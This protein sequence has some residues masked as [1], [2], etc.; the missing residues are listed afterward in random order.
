M[1]TPI[2]SLVVSLAAETAAFRRDISAARGS[3]LSLERSVT[4]M[5]RS[6]K[7]A[8]A[9][10][11]TVRTMAKGVSSLAQS[12]MEAEQATAAL[13]GTVAGPDSLSA[14]V[15][16]ATAEWKDYREALATSPAFLGPVTAAVKALG[17]ALK[18][19]RPPGEREVLLDALRVSHKDVQGWR[20]LLREMGKS[21]EFIE[22]LGRQSAN[23]ATLDLTDSEQR[24]LEALARERELQ[25]DLIALAERRKAQRETAPAAPGAPTPTAP[26][27]DDG[28][29]YQQ[30]LNRLAAEYRD[31]IARLTLVTSEYERHTLDL[32]L[33][34][35]QSADATVD[36]VRAL[37]DHEARLK[38][39]ANAIQTLNREVGVV[40]SSIARYW[41]DAEERRVRAAEEANEQTEQLRKDATKHATDSALATQV[42]EIRAFN[43][44][45]SRMQ[46]SFADTFK[47]L[48]TGE[49]TTFRDFTQQLL[50][51]W[52]EMLAQMA[53]AKLASKLFGGFLKDEG[54]LAGV[55]GAVAGE[56]KEYHSGGLVTGG[57]YPGLRPDEVP[58][59]LQ[60][61]EYV[62]PK[63]QMR[64][65][66]RPQT[67]V[68]Q[69]IILNVSAIDSRGVQQLLTEQA[70]TIAAIVAR[71]A[72]GSRGV[73]RQLARGTE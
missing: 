21:E 43:Q 45:V 64:G 58:A 61:G 70:P 15:A 36:Q 6:V 65:S 37:A 11:L 26:T 51:L 63:G 14:A 16:E 68:R 49:I 55:V 28:K 54:A 69:T 22:W 57:G 23:D 2:G 73:A 35:K 27:G 38:T 12:A 59:I 20:D 31:N 44:S 71:A 17:G 19:L 72:K 24:Y 41:E 18:E 30:T 25:R 47:D 56:A 3:V 53:A 10:F 50:S 48:L 9:S 7:V 29:R 8:L 39:S 34:Q 60:A 52:A 46:D 32:A 66:R 62:V 67:V 33:S 5:G 4:G 13:A 42:A 40:T 1:P